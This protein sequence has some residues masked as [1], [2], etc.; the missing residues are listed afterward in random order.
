MS[1]LD[2]ATKTIAE[3]KA[4]I[5]AQARRELQSKVA[6]KV[7][8]PAVFASRIQGETEAD[9]EEDAAALLAAMPG[10]VAPKLAPTNPGSPQT[11]E[12]DEARR[13]RLGLAPLRRK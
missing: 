4:Q 10:T 2:K 6:D 9:M 11:G 3:L 12:T 5:A 13:E 7:G 8:L 1:E